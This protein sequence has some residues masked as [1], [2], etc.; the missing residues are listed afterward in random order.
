MTLVDEYISLYQAFRIILITLSY[1]YNTL[2]TF[3]DGTID[4]IVQLFA[5]A[6]IKQ[7]D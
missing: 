1:I 6:I 7:I 5:T 4:L 2:Y 3:R